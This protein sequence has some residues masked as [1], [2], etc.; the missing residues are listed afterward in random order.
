[1]I[2]LTSCSLVLIL[3]ILITPFL[4]AQELDCEVRTNPERARIRVRLRS[5]L[6]QLGLQEDCGRLTVLIE[7]ANGSVTWS[8]RNF[9]V[10]DFETRANLAYWSVMKPEPSPGDELELRCSFV[11]DDGSTPLASSTFFV[12]PG[13]EG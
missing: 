3:L 7:T 9:H 11:P 4:V 12:R 13:L 6:V 10:E 8:V 5:P 2:L 1:M